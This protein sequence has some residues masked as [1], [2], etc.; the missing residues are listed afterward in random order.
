MPYKRDETRDVTAF[1]PQVEVTLRD[2]EALA[3]MQELLGDP[4]RRVEVPQA[5]PDEESVPMPASR[6]YEIY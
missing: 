5:G 3:Q 1:S 4:R 2:L 6:R